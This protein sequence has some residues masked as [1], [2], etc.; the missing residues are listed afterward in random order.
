[1]EGGRGGEGE[2]KEGKRVGREGVGGKYGGR[3]EG[4]GGGERGW[5]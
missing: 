4:K 5:R 3:G 1:M 2:V